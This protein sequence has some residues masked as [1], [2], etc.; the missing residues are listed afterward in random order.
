MQFRV[1][2]PRVAEE[3]Y[4]TCG[5]IDRHNKNRL[6]RLDSE[7]KFEIKEWSLRVITTLLSVCVVDAWL[8]HK[9]SVGPKSTMSQSLLSEKLAEKLIGNT[10]DNLGARCSNISDVPDERVQALVSGVGFSWCEPIRKEKEETAH[11]AMLFARAAA[12]GAN[13]RKTEIHLL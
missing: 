3:Y 8:V 12:V 2:S 6:N 5:Q 11:L 10:Y 1:P 7:K 4:K 13:I 9:H